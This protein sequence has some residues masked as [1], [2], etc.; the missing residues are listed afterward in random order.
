[1]SV[2]TFVLAMVSKLR[3]QYETRRIQPEGFRVDKVYFTSW[4]SPEG[5]ETIKQSD[6]HR[7]F[8]KYDDLMSKVVTIL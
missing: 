2:S 6:T 3:P 5:R 8:G 1:M 7:L 4:S